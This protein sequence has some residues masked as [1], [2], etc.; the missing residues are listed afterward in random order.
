MPQIWLGD[1]LQT[2][3]FQTTIEI[4]NRNF[5]EKKQRNF[6]QQNESGKTVKTASIDNLKVLYITVFSRKV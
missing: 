1:D 3:K 2:Q 5:I 4:L 6:R